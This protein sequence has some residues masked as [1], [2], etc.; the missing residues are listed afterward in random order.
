MKGITT[1]SSTI[2][3]NDEMTTMNSVPYWNSGSFEF[4]EFAE[5]KSMNCI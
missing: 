4:G 2:K 3:K 5:L 1:K